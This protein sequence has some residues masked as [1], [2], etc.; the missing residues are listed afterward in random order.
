MSSTRDGTLS[1]FGKDT[2]KSA[3]F[4]SLC[5]PKSCSMRITEDIRKMASEESLPKGDNVPSLVKLKS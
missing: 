3:H 4:C 2:F 1:P 5:G